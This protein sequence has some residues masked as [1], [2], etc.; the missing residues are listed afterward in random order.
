MKNNKFLNYIKVFNEVKP[1]HKSPNGHSILNRYNSFDWNGVHSCEKCMFY[2]HNKE[3]IEE[4][5]EE[6]TECD[7]TS[8]IH[9]ATLIS[10]V[11]E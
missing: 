10:E 6:S 9:H 7:M 11:T 8:C 2:I 4:G 1:R 3:D 5:I